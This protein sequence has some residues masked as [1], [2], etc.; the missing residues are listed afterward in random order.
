MIVLLQYLGDD[1]QMVETA[2][3]YG[4]WKDDVLTI[5]K[6]VDDDGDT[7]LRP[8]SEHSEQV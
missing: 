2:E 3:T 6:E 5:R 4:R 8:H 7:R 1:F